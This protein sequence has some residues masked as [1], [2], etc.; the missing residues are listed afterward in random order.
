MM[1]RKNLKYPPYYFLCNLKISG[2]D[3][4]YISFE[5]MKIKRSLERNLENVIVLGPSS[6]SVFKVNN[7]YRYNI[8]LKYKKDESLYS[9]LSK[10]VDHYKANSKIRIDI[11]F[12][13]S[14]VL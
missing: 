7:I 6:A 1:I 2:K 3:A 14:Q 5:A 13:P 9:I 12:N 8:I 4:N 10:I 11:D